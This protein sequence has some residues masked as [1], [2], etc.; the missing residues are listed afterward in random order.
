MAQETS[1]QEERTVEFAADE[2][3][4][5]VFKL[6]PEGRADIEAATVSVVYLI[7]MLVFFGWQFVDISTG[8]MLLLRKILQEN[9]DKLNSDMCRII[10]Y[11]VIGGALG[12]IVNGFRSILIWHA[13]RR[14]FGWRHLWKYITLPLLGATLAA[15]VYALTRAGF[16]VIGGESTPGSDFTVQA[17]SAFAIGALSGYGSPKVFKWLDE[18]VNKWFKISAVAE[19]KVPPLKGKTEQQV[20]DALRKLGLNLGAVSEQISADDA[21]IN[22]VISQ[23]PPADTKVLKASSVDITI[24]KKE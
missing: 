21:E 8:R 3:T 2:Q 23:S 14:A 19:V 6:E 4:G 10:A 16:V 7:L 17:F 24:A 5:K 15:I 22:K 13:E 20:K 18:H 1:T 11:A 9:A 12:G